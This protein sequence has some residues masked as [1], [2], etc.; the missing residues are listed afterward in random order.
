MRETSNFLRLKNLNIES[1][2]TKQKLTFEL[3]N[4]ANRPRVHVFGFTFMPT[5]THEMYDNLW[6]VIQDDVSLNIFGFANWKNIYMSNW[7]LG[8]EFRYVFDRRYLKRY[9]GNTL[10]RP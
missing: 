2:D 3:S 9:L 5:Y 1:K 10:D 6:R 7:K 4:Y 8:D